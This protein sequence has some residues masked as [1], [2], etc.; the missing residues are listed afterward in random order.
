MILGRECYCIEEYDIH[1]RP[2]VVTEAILP[3]ENK[4]TRASD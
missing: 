2:V 1:G 4:N 3:L